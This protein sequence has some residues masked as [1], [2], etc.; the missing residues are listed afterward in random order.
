M[1]ATYRLSAWRRAVN[2][3]VCGLLGLGPRHTHLLTV[4]GRRTGQ[5]RSTPV[6]LVVEGPHRWLVAPYGAVGWVRNQALRDRGADHPPVLRRDPAAPLDAFVAEAPR[7][8]VF[9]IAEGGS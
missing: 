7:H 8:P 3:A 5:P 6:T 2:G 9:R 1:A 4:P